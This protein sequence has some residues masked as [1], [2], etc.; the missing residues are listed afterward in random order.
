LILPAALPQARD[1]DFLGRIKA[2]M[3]PPAYFA[4]NAATG[5]A[6]RKR[7]RQRRESWNRSRKKSRKNE[8]LRF[9]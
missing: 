7:D 5:R 1:P 9:N 8:S 3:P 2:A 6:D 4:S